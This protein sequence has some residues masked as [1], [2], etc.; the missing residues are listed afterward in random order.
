[1]HGFVSFKKVVTT[2]RRRGRLVEA[3]GRGVLRVLTKISKID[4][5]KYALIVCAVCV[6]YDSKLEPES[7]SRSLF[8]EAKKGDTVLRI[9]FCDE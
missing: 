6:D 8:V 5:G 7:Y 9:L 3:G 4:R 1:M 2:Q